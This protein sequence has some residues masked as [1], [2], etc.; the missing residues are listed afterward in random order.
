MPLSVLR[1]AYTPEKL[2]VT[3]RLLDELLLEARTRA[4]RASL[5]IRRTPRCQPSTSA[6]ITPI[7]PAIEASRCTRIVGHERQCE[8]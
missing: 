1:R 6:A 2:A 7:R 3:Y 4:A 5:R 8:I